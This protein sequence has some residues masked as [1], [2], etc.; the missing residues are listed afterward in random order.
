MSQTLHLI[1]AGVSLAP[2]TLL[3]IL[4]LA[5]HRC[6]SDG[7]LPVTGARLI[8]G[9]SLLCAL[10]GVV[11]QVIRPQVLAPLGAFDPGSWLL[12]SPVSA[13][14]TL[15]VYLLAFVIGGFSLR[16]LRGEPLT[17]RLVAC[18]LWVIASVHL[19]L[20]ANHWLLMLFAWSLIGRALEPL[21]CF[22]PD[23]P[24]ARLAALKKRLAD[25][26]ADLLIIGAAALA[27]SAVGSGS[28]SDLRLHLQ[29]GPA[30]LPIQLSAVCLVVA[31]ILRTAALP[32]H[33]WLI[34]VMEAPT[35]VSALL[36]AGVVNLGGIVL[37]RLSAL[38]DAVPLARWILVAVGLATAILAGMVMLTRISIK[39]RLAW[40]TVA[41]MGF[42][43][44]ECGLG[45]YTIAALHIVGHSIYKAHA[46]LAASSIVRDTRIRQIQ[47][48]AEVSFLSLIC[49]PLLAWA[50]L[51]GVAHWAGGFDWPVWWSTVIAFAWAPLLWWPRGEP[52]GVHQRLWQVCVSLIVLSG[53]AWAAFLIHALP[54]G[55]MDSPGWLAG[56]LAAVAFG[57]LYL[58]LAWIQF[59]PES[60]AGWRRRA[61]A[62][63]YLDEFFTRLTL[64]FAAARW[65]PSSPSTA[66]PVRAQESA[67][68]S[69]VDSRECK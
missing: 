24:F 37:I 27:W 33:G 6:P 45:L 56:M 65:M 51:W 44:L 8:A 67:G 40:S 28:L 4:A 9:F 21:L 63:F 53:L 29:A 68:R 1:L 69:A 55:L 47:R 15:L 13:W 17:P 35:P 43:L 11:V 49:A 32:I 25:R 48:P 16:Y 60:L 19:L 2:L 52:G 41:Q 22:Y 66:P 36:H 50:V 20:M 59:H 23:R 54:L 10:T 62:G 12:V 46:F 39:V 42:M 30:S 61:Y 3:A 57:L 34:Q 31:V 18:F 14:F 5:A 58:L 7:P 26:A 38:L 64:R